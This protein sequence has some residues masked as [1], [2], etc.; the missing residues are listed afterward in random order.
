[1]ENER[2]SM[3]IVVTRNDLYRQVW[4]TPLVQLAARYKTTTAELTTMCTRMNVPRPPSG[5]WLKKSSGKPVAQDELP[6]ADSKTILETTIATTPE[7]PGSSPPRVEFE[8]QL[9]IARARYAGLYVP[10]DIGHPHPLIERWLAEHERKRRETSL[11]RPKEF[12]ALDHRRFRFLD[13]LFKAVGKIGFECRVGELDRAY[14]SFN[15]ERVDFTLRERQKQVGRPLDDK[16]Y[17][18]W[19]KELRPTGDLV[20]KITTWLPHEMPTAWRDN[21]QNSLEW[22]LDDI[23][24]VVSLV[25]PH[26][27]RQRN[28]KAAEQKRRWEEER[29]QNLARERRERDDK[30]WLKMLEFAQQRDLA[31]SVR[32]LLVD[33]ELNPRPEGSFGGLT[34]DEWLAWARQWLDRFDPLIRG[35]M[36]LYEELAAIRA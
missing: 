7:K 20:F 13:A 31:E 27:V 19:S 15:G 26:L 9:S 5:F 34:S 35:P 30:R 16:R 18:G 6:P 4:S 33:I 10:E 28:L 29:R 23:I 32:R 14:L 21:S 3:P 24:A 17:K 11:F 25:G 12:T 2:Q 36:S 8:N 22:Q 1:M